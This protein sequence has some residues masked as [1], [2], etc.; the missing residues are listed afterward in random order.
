MEERDVL[1]GLMELDGVG[2]ET[3]QHL[4]ER[5]KDIREVFDRSATQILKGIDI[6]QTKGKVIDKFLTNE[7]IEG[8]LRF[9]KDCGVN[10]ITFFDAEYPPLLRYVF[11][12]PWVLYTLGNVELFQRPSVAI[13]GTR[14]PTRYGREVAEWFGYEIAAA[15]IPVVSGLARGIDSCAHAGALQSTGDTIAVLG[16]G[17]N[18]RY[19]PE[20]HRLQREIEERGLVVSE[21]G[22]NTKPVKGTFPFRN[23]IIAGLSRGT[24]VVEA[25]EKSGTVI[26]TDFAL[27]FGRDIFAV[28]GLITSPK[29]AGVYKLIREGA[30]LAIT[31]RDVISEYV[32]LKDEGRSEGEQSKEILTDDEQEVLQAMGVEAVTVDRLIDLTAYSFG[33]L[34]SVLLS[35]LVKK[36]IRALPGSAYIVRMN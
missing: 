22:W 6:I 24:L 9:Y 35:L 3:V 18:V 31:P 16:N 4:V 11:R 34:H 8:K 2:W 23:R 25:S 32:S 5:T 14:N 15:G 27:N 28:P 1:F 13:V 19:P 10:I 12:P 26:T 36:R 29:S 17:L 20:H 7:F 21:Y 30:K 33:H